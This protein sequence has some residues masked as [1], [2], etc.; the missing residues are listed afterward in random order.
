MFIYPSFILRSRFPTSR[1]LP[2]HHLP[3]LYLS[4][5]CLIHSAVGL[6][7]PVD[8]CLIGLTFVSL[9]SQDSVPSQPYHRS[10]TLT[11]FDV[12]GYRPPIITPAISVNSHPIDCIFSSLNSQD[13]FLSEVLF[14]INV[15]FRGLE[16]AISA[17]H[18]YLHRP[19]TT[20]APLSTLTISTNSCPIDLILGSVLSDGI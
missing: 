6:L 8:S 16:I 4:N 19:P 11:A 5:S 18:S 17:A 12:R 14:I 13:S 10:R 3:Q 7:N 9:N 2:H 15:L 1:L 20:H